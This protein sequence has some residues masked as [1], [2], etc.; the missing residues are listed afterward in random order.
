MGGITLTPL[1]IIALILSEKKNY[2]IAILSILFFVLALGDYNV[3]INILAVFPYAIL[4]HFRKLLQQIFIRK[5]KRFCKGVQGKKLF[6]P[7]KA[8][9]SFAFAKNEQLRKWTA[10]IKFFPC[11]EKSQDLLEM[12]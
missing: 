12:L 6:Q 3:C 4:E 8:T 7:P 1:L 10:E 2:K 5:L 9:K 11:I